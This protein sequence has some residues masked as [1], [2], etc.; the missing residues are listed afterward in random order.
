MKLLLFSIRF[1]IRVQSFSHE[2][3][4]YFMWLL[5]LLKIH[6]FLMRLYQPVIEGGVPFMMQMIVMMHLT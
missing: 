4:I 1:L 5:Y 6:K 3:S 2:L